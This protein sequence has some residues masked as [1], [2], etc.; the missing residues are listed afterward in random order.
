L[1]AQKVERM[2]A[3]AAVGEYGLPIATDPFTALEEEL[4]RSNGYVCFLDWRVQSLRDDEQFGLVGG[5]PQA[6]PGSEPH[7]LIRMLADERKHLAKI[8][9][10]CIDAGIAKRRVELAESQGQALAA[11]I[12]RILD[13]LGVLE[14]PEAPEV[15]REELSRLSQGTTE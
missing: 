3:E 7:V 5:G 8:A 15:V 13:R 9:K 14:H 4:A 6:I 10:T 2:R 11:T 1:Y 12:K